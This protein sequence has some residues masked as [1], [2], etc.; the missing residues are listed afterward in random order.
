MLMEALDQ[1]G[2]DDVLVPDRG[3]AASERFMRSG[4]DEARVTLNAS[5]TYDV[6]EGEVRP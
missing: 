1:L 5:S 3:W 6:G 2:F 4:K